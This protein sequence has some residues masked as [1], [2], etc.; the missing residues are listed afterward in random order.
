MPH[1]LFLSQRLS[2]GNNQTMTL[3]KTFPFC[4]QHLLI[5]QTFRPQH[6]DSH[7][8]TH[9]HILNGGENTVH[10][11]TY[12]PVLQRIRAVSQLLEMWQLRQTLDMQ[13]S[14]L[15]LI[16]TAQ[17]CRAIAAWLAPQKAFSFLFLSYFSSFSLCLLLQFFDFSAVPMASLLL[18][19][20]LER[21]YW[22]IVL[23]Y[24]SCSQ[25]DDLIVMQKM[26]QRLLIGEW[27]WKACREEKK[28][29]HL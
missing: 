23:N 8:H 10:S 14:A 26:V 6:T 27:G 11:Q 20:V 22:N 28:N 15:W 21:H 1:A 19:A 16:S 29:P 4:L 9:T 2:K 17:L 24:V 12:T 13:A 25:I 18:I 7:T 3:S 5:P